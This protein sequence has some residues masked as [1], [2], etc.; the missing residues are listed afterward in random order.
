MSGVQA[1]TGPCIL[2]FSGGTA[3]GPVASALTRRTRNAVHVITTFDSGGSSAELRRV[4]DMPAVGDVR[5]RL[6]ALADTN[7][8]GYAELKK[9][10]AWRLPLEASTAELREELRDLAEG[11]HPLIL[12]IP[13]GQR[14]AAVR[15]LA[16]FRAIL[17]E[18]MN[19][20]GACIGNLALTA[21]YMGH[22]RQLDPVVQFFS[23]LINASGI[24]HPVAND[25]AHLCV[26]LEN[27]EVIVGQHRFT[28]K[29]RSVITS[30]IR[31][32]W[33]SAALDD[34]SPVH[35]GILPELAATIHAADLIC[36]PVGSFYSS[37][38]ANLLPDG[39]GEA[40]RKAPCP[41]V[42]MPNLS[43]DP[44]LLGRSIQDQVS[45]LLQMVGAGDDPL[46]ALNFLLVD[47]NDALYPGGIPEQWLAGKGIRVHRAPLVAIPPYLEPESVCE[48]LCALT[49][50]G[51]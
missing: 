35:V 40:I 33:L 47:Q 44:E 28:N 34:D 12:A 8:S 27:G 51:C 25:C 20:A 1:G 22:N 15:Y 19:L 17:P 32:M 30:P 6:I 14:P 2:F 37:V 42:F 23:R 48:Q 5:A 29:T 18:N 16:Q 45:C 10:F 26:Q 21:A 41:K 31:R 43:G 9:L 3:L 7:I 24:V 36:Y 50:A 39:V 46:S 11:R 13:E 38:M 4:F 49:C